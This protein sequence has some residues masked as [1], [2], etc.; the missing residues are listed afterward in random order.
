MYKRKDNILKTIK[1]RSFETQLLQN[2]MNS[3]KQLNF[4]LIR[5]EVKSSNYL[6]TIILAYQ[7]LAFYMVLRYYLGRKERWYNFFY[8]FLNKYFTN[9]KEMTMYIGSVHSNIQRD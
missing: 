9:K 1:E 3:T 6:R 2:Y 4:A 5:R 7:C 8:F